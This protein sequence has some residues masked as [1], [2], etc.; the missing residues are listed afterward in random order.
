MK[1][2]IKTEMTRPEFFS[3]ECDTKKVEI[4]YLDFDNDDTKPNSIEVLKL[5][6]NIELGESLSGTNLKDLDMEAAQ[7][8][9]DNI[10]ESKDIPKF[11][12][13]GLSKSE[14][15]NRIDIR[16]SSLSDLIARTGRIGKA[17]TI[18]A[19]SKTLKEYNFSGVIDDM[20][21]CI[22][23]YVED[24]TFYLLHNG[25]VAEQPGFKF[26]YH[27]DENGKEYYAFTSLGFYP[28][29][30]ATKFVIYSEDIS[31]K[32]IDRVAY[33]K[34]ID[35]I[36]DT[37]ELQKIMYNKK[38]EKEIIDEKYKNIINTNIFKEE[39]KFYNE[40][41]E[42]NQTTHLSPEIMKASDKK[43]E[44]IETNNNKN[45]L[46]SIPL[47]YVFN[48]YTTCEVMM[49]F[50]NEEPIKFGELTNGVDFTLTL[51]NNFEDNVQPKIM[52]KNDNGKKF[53]LFI[54]PIKK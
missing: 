22:N 34:I 26:L 6:K 28:E 37:T 9:K 46:S 14:L 25:K 54:Q 36:D 23:D 3:I 49:Q 47:E 20:T 53:S 52:F 4:T 10:K 7:F 41:D 12:K 2:K 27:I 5:L 30:Q 35:N 33:T 8:L 17:N 44:F 31:D 11:S 19:N 51:I 21:V 29:R 13:F 40:L 38:H 50:D 24:N 45:I 39:E 1:T 16:L 18:V 48:N 42:F 15:T 32:N 43:T